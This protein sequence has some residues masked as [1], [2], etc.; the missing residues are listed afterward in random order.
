MTFNGGKP[1]KAMTFVHP[2]ILCVVI[3]S[4]ACAQTRSKTSQTRS[5][6]EKWFQQKVWLHGLALQPHKSI[7]A[8]EFARQYH[9]HQSLWDSAFAF[10]AHNDLQTLPK[11]KYPILGDSVYASITED[12]TKDY[13][14]TQWESHRRYADIQYVIRG[15]E[16]IGE[17]PLSKAV[18]T[19]AYD[20]K[21]DIARY[22]ATGKQ[23]LARPGTFFI[24]FPADVH[25][26]NITTGV[27]K[28]DKKL[29]IKVLMTKPGA[30]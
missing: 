19:Q 23:Y 30:Q 15:E 24:F 21:N 8:L 7:D 12:P 5:Q 17:C 20:A 16:K 13:E 9:L 6:A 10:F 29:V 14:N 26:P 4:L 11:G 2:L 22:N 18:V 1:M 3:G 28:V 27:Q 25:R